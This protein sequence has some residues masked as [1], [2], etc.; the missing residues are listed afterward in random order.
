MLI[1]CDPNETADVTLPGA[2][3]TPAERRPTFVYRHFTGR[4]I[5]ERERLFDAAQGVEAVAVAVAVG[6]VGWR[7]VT[8]RDGRPLAF[9]PAKIP[10]VLTPLELGELFQAAGSIVQLN[11]VQKKSSRL[12]SAI[13]PAP[14]A[15]RATTKADA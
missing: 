6:L 4:Q 5:I 12:A 7:N 8:D 2:D 13:A 15:E 9:D 3:A 11:E 14:S 10:D 1:A